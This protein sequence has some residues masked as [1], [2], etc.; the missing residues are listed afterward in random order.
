MSSS[1]ERKGTAAEE[2][3][4]AIVGGKRFLWVVMV[5][6]GRAGMRAVAAN[7]ARAS[8]EEQAVT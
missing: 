6:E 5:W 3:F 4:F 2:S 8:D 1:V 7:R